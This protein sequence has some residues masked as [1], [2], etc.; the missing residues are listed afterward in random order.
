MPCW[1]VL[2]LLVEIC[3]GIIGKV[4]FA[5]KLDD[6]KLLAITNNVVKYCKFELL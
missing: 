1:V 3:D 4:V 5:D 2:A 6:N